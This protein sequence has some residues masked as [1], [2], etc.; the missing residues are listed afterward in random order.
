MDYENQGQ[1]SEQALVPL[2]DALTKYRDDMR[3]AAKTKDFSSI[4]D[5]SDKVRDDVLP[6]LGIRLEDVG[7]NKVFSYKIF[8]NK[9]AFCVEI[10]R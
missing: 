1:N 8:L 5:I 4:L 9:K 3:N 7:N 6:E 2:M 10:P